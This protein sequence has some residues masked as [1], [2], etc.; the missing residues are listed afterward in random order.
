[1]ETFQTIAERFGFP[2]AVTALLMF[3][4]YKLVVFFLN[5]IATPLVEGHVKLMGGMTDSLNQQTTTLA[6]IEATQIKHGQRINDIAEAVKVR[7]G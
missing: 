5:K 4:G 1:M 3:G 7:V 2:V 6:N